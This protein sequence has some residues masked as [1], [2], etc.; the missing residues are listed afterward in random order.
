MPTLSL[1]II[2]KDVEGFD[3]NTETIK[4]I[5]AQLDGVDIM[6]LGSYDNN[7]T[8]EEV[9]LEFKSFLSGKGYNWDSEV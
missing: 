5:S 3:G 7:M 1:T 6:D 2:Q 9:T 4:R 8:D